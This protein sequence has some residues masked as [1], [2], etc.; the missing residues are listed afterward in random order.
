M[1]NQPWFSQCLLSWRLLCQTGRCGEVIYYNI[2]L[3]WFSLVFPPTFEADSSVFA[4]LSKKWF[5][6]EQKT[7]ASWRK[8]LYLFVKTLTHI[9]DCNRCPE[10]R[11]EQGKCL[12][13]QW[14]KKTVNFSRDLLLAPRLGLRGDGCMAF[15]QCPRH[16][17]PHPNH[18]LCPMKGPGT[19]CHWI[20]RNHWTISTEE[21]A[22]MFSSTCE[23]MCHNAKICSLFRAPLFHEPFPR[24][25]TANFVFYNFILFF[26]KK[27]L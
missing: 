17:C 26:L 3:C 15:D 2:N 27:T 25:C 14:E 4:P 13:K 23:Q 20:S 9:G 21:Q 22:T 10:W 19:V 7:R 12:W 16:Q 1:V 8:A 18:F 6:A 5:A 24:L 11:E